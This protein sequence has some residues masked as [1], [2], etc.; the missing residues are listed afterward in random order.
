MLFRQVSAEPAPRKR[1][2]TRWLMSDARLGKAMPKIAASMP[3]RSAIVVRPYAL[4]HGGQAAL[5][6]SLRR[7]ARAKRH[8]LLLAGDG[9]VAGYDG[10]HLGG[11]ARLQKSAGGFCSMPV[12]DRREAITAQRMRVDAVLISPVFA[13]RSHKDARPLGANGFARVAALFCGRSIA[14]GGMTQRNFARLR[15]HAAGWAAIDAWL[16]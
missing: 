16:R 10:R 12:H 6:R 14:L 8:L 15:G 7:V 9:S 2:P 11:A 5:I 13:T 4:A 3:P 1:V